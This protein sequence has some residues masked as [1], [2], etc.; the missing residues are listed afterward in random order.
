MVVVLV[1]V[2]PVDVSDVGVVVSVVVV[3]VVVVV[4]VDVVPVDVSV[5]GV[6]V[7]VVVE[8]AEGGV[9]GKELGTCSTSPGWKLEDITPLPGGRSA[10]P[11]TW[12][13]SW[14]TTVRRSMWRLGL[15]DGKST[16]QPQ[17]AAVLEMLIDVP[18]VM[19]SSRSGRSEEVA[20]THERSALGAIA[21]QSE[22]A[23]VTAADSSEEVTAWLTA[24]VGADAAVER[25]GFAV[26]VEVEG[27]VEEVEVVVES[28]PVDPVL[29]DPVP[30]DPVDVESVEVDPELPEV[31]VVPVDVPLEVV[32]ED[33][34]PTVTVCVVLVPLVVV[35]V[36]P[37]LLVVVDVEL[38]VVVTGH[39]TLCAW[40]TTPGPKLQLL[41]DDPVVEGFD[42]DVVG[43]GDSCTPFAPLSKTVTLPTG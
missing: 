35:V 11:S 29:V 18:L 21:C 1:D 22:I 42:V 2:V 8:H 25:A 27:S 31:L 9:P 23:W 17:P 4:P 40:M 37:S 14:R 33:G 13:T 15:S 39:E 10:R 19:P 5:V 26:E 34:A 7:S 28:V 24:V 20:E 3:G 32:E 41:V 16:L 38:L 30:V 6:V 43:A 36:V 12:P